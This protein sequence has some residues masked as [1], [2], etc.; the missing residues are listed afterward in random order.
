MSTFPIDLGHRVAV[1]AAAVSLGLASACDAPGPGVH[2][3]AT[4]TNATR[5][6]VGAWTA[7]ER[8]LLRSISL[9][10]LRAPPPDPS[11]RVADDPLAAAFG[12]RLFFDP[13]LSREG[14][15]SCASC[16][17]P[18]RAFTDGRATSVGPLPGARNAPTLLGA[19]W[20]PWLYWDG[21]R[22]SLWSQALAPIETPN[23]LASTRVG[24]LR[25]VTAE[26]DHAA[27]YRE[28]FGPLPRL[29]ER[30]DTLGQAGPFGRASERQAWA[31]LSEAER[32]AIDEAFAN[33]G[34][35]IAAF[36]RTL[37]PPRTRF[38][39]YA[40]AL[41]EGRDAEA[42][43]RLGPEEQAGLRLFLDVA[44]TRCLQCHNGPLLTNHAFHDVA[45]GRRGAVPDLGR[46]I[47]VA[48]LL[49]D[50]FNCL[51]PFSDA[52][53][54]DCDALQSLDRRAAERAVGAFRTPTL[55][56]LRWT[57]PYLHDGSAKTLREVIEHYRSPPDGAPG[58][59]V[60][61]DLD[62]AE[63]R[64]LVAFLE[65]LSS[66]SSTDRVEPEAGMPH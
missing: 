36:E 12:R 44:R 57:G 40:A 61:L 47:G 63:A 48:A 35:A 23:E 25:F 41:I 11:N 59:L 39:D 5:A 10:A 49:R 4:S 60:P 34:K 8:A 50:P 62:E 27:A 28:V 7:G 52:A 65:T 19:A 6:T 24:V 18:R 53:P 26:P 54:A 46:A 45:T 21:R 15:L 29:P 30:L 14:R 31:G 38:D 22:D 37:R 58:E 32:R 55:R 64:Q 33:V 51:G 9:E 66:R 56:E 20:S 17:D 13:G 1:L 16:H 3:D 2:A 42:P 43:A